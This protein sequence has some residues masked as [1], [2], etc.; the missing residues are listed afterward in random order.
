MRWFLGCVLTGAWLAYWFVVGG[1]EPAAVARMTPEDLQWLGF[2]IG[3]PLVLVWL[4][5]G[6]LGL[7]ARL[8]RLG[9]TVRALERNV[10]RGAADTPA[11][12]R[13]RSAA[14]PVSYEPAPGIGSATRASGSEPLMSAAEPSPGI[15]ER[16][17]PVLTAEP[18]RPTVTGTR[19]VGAD[20]VVA[21]RNDGGG[22]RDL[23]LG[24]DRGIQAGVQPRD[25]VGAGENAEILFR[26]LTGEFPGRIGFDVSFR[27]AGGE[28]RT[29]SLVFVVPEGRIRR[30][31]PTP[32]LTVE[33][34]ARR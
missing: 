24:A 10:D 14:A 15:T 1:V 17:D 32:A 25:R 19:M 21:I 27:D 6:F 2:Q 33:A 7:S 5:L 22:A 23:M 28:V 11:V 13:S 8:R 26:A 30:R 20:L 29:E 16:N 34:R 4:L 12:R 18:F 9:E 3:V 31:E